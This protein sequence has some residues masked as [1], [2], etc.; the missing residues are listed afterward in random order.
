V[1]DAVPLDA[2]VI[3]AGAGFAGIGMAIQ[4]DKH[5]F[6]SFLVLESASDVGG[7]WRDNRYPGCACDIPSALYSYSFERNPAWT[8]VF[9]RQDELWEYL[10]GCVDKYELRSRMRFDSALREARYDD[11]SSTWRL[12]TASGAELTCRVLVSAMGFLNRPSIPALPGFERF[13]G[14]SFHTAEWDASADLRDKRVAVIGTGASAIQIVPEIAL[15]VGELTLFQR[16]PPWVIPRND[17]PIGARLRA[18]RRLLPGYT[19]ALRTLLYWMLEIRAFGF[20]VRP[21]LLRSREAL[22]L[23]HLERQVPEPELR[24]ALTPDYRM[25]CKRILLSDDY[26]PALRRPN[27]SVVTSPIAEVREDAVVTA[28]GVAHAADVL[29]FATGFKATEGFGPV[30]VFGRGGI[31]LSD[32]WRD[33]MAAYLGTSVAGF[34][35][36]FTL[37]GPNTGLGHNSMVVMMEAQF[38]YV[39]SAL[40]LMRRRGVRA[41]D[42]RRTVQDSFNQSLQARLKKTVWASGCHS[43]YL[44]AHGKNTT[45]WPG[46]TFAYRFLTRRLDPTRYELLEE[47]PTG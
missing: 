12:T 18:L 40:R 2:E 9:P 34:P 39:L 16:T 27:V 21:E 1:V 45:L 31:E 42:V 17:A 4:L 6:G 25:G 46:F 7:T 19:R 10:R 43:W 33:G 36:F 26:Y 37:I 44:D 35:N 24:R 8:R 3:I 15:V 22:A 28:D 20:T 32:A 47:T 5:G 23:R 30:R 13:R 41:L 29:I 14:K 11:A 38:R